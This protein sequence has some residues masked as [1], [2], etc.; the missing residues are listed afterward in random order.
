MKG[1]PLNIQTET[2]IDAPL[3]R[4]WQIAIDEFE[5]IGKWTTTIPH[6]RPNPDLS[7]D[8]LGRVCGVPGFGEIKE[9]VI[10][11]D[12]VAHT[13]TYKADGM[14]FFIRYIQNAWTLQ[15]VGEKT[16]ITTNATGELMPII[17]RILWP[18]MR[19]Q[20]R[21]ITRAFFAEL[22]HYAETGSIHP[23]KIK[24]L[25]HSTPPQSLASS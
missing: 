14:P 11:L 24:Q 3:E 18:F 22:K 8:E 1:H 7:D 6:S 13:F 25:Q 10:Q 20:M 4:V 16:K 5:D 15:V 23:D 2:M 9:T 21:S 17:G 19:W 12:D